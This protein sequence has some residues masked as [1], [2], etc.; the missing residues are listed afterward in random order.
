MKYLILVGSLE[1]IDKLM[2][3]DTDVLFNI[4]CYTA[5]PAVPI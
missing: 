4:L 2:I 1:S 3:A 5:T